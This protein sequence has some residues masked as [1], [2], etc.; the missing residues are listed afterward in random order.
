MK[1]GIGPKVNLLIISAMVLVGGAAVFFSVSALKH[2]GQI[3]I[4]KYSS[5]MMELKKEHIKDLVSSAYTIAKARLDV[6]RDKNAIRKTY[7]DNAKAVVNQAIAVFEANNIPDDFR[8]LEERR[9]NAVKVIDKMRWGLNGT[10]Y[11]WIQDMNGYMIHHPL[12]KNLNGKFLRDIKDPDGV[13]LFVEMERLAKKDGGG[14]VDYKWPKPGFNKPQDKISYVKLF[15]PWNWIIGAGVYLEST[16]K[17]AQQDALRNIGAIRYGKN[18]LG[19]F[20][21]YDSN[22]NC[23]LMP[24]R[25]EAVG[26][27]EWDLKDS[28]GLY[29][30]RELVKKANAR[31]EG[32]F[33]S[34]FYNKPG[35]SENIKKI[36][37][38]RKLPEWDWYIGTG[39]YT[40]DVDA[41]VAN[42]Q[43]EIGRNVKA[44]TMKIL[45]IVLGIMVLSVVISYFVVAKGVVAPLRNMINMLKDIASGEGDLTKRIIDTSGDETQELSEGFNQFIENIQTMIAKI[46][47]DTGDLTDA[48]SELA[49]ISEQLNSAAEETS[50]RADSV[51]SASEKMSLNMDSMSA[52]MAQASSNI[53]MVSAASEEMSSTISEIAHNA[54]KARD[55]TI[56]AVG[57]AEHASTQVEDLG[58][59]AKEIFTVVETITEISSQVN[60]LALNATIEAARAGEAGKGFA[61]VANEIKDL[62]NQTARA[63]S[64]IKERVAGIRQSTE[65]TTAE[66]VSITKV[67]GEINEIVSTIAAAVEEQSSTTN[68]IAQNISQASLGISEVNENIAEGSVMAKGVSGDVG[69]VTTAASQIVDASRQV[70]NKAADLSKLAETLALMMSKFKV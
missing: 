6:A 49:G 63:S 69:E 9:A 66:I 51:T 34:Y 48:S 45:S 55:I 56:Q 11:F 32:D 47:G 67:V 13:K 7:G 43:K 22:G 62:A 64:Q 50:G 10:N 12:I 14:F 46:K 60:L 20:F 42:E 58:I 15:T 33:L 36:S 17:E 21:I 37:Y 41:A 53:N 65:G 2:E 23:V 28:K 26:T 70:K 1:L 30:I 68:E 61:V 4:E 40:D 39:T 44:A 35:A 25:P 57:Q 54:E 38:V 29:I 59:A 52:A 5:D 27:N 31:T 3:A 24:P 18:G 16:E 19:Y 8:P